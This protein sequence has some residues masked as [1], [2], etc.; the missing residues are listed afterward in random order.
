MSVH[1]MPEQIAAIKA[2][3]NKHVG[4]LNCPTSFGKTVTIYGHIKELLETKEQRICAIISGPIMD[5][6][7]QTAESVLIY[8]M[9]V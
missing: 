9:T 3:S 2:M 6:N 5:L 1:L 7:E 4:F 8:T